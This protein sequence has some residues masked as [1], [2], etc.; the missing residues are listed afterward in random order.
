MNR[1]PGAL[2]FLGIKNEALGSGA[3]HHNE[4]F[5][6]DEAALWRGAACYAGFALEA[7]CRDTPPGVSA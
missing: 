4:R 3:E 1:W 5:D 2:A 7:T 6:L